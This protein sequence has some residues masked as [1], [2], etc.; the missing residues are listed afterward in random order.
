MRAVV[1][2]APL[3]QADGE[4]RPLRLVM[5]HWG[6]GEPTLGSDYYSFSPLVAYHSKAIT[7]E[8]LPYSE[9]W[10]EDWICDRFLP[11]Q[12]D[13]CISL[14]CGFGA[15]ERMLY[16]RGLFRECIAYDISPGALATARRLAEEQGLT[17]LRYEQADINHLQLPAASCDLV[18]ANGALHHITRLEHVLEQVHTAL[19]PGGI[20]VACEYVGP[21]HQNLP[22]RQRELV[23][24]VSYLLPPELRDR[25]PGSFFPPAFRHA[26]PLKLAYSSWQQFGKGRRNDAPSARPGRRGRVERGFH[27]AG[28]FVGRLCP[29]DPF[30]F[31]KLWDYDPRHFRRIDPSEC[32]RSSDVIPV[33]RNVFADVDVR[34]FHGSLLQHA[35]DGAFYRNF[36]SGNRHHWALLDQLVGIER[37]AIERGEI[38]SDNA[39][40]IAR[41]AVA[42]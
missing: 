17:G 1:E 16:A 20:L 42:P 9:S 18:W 14:C 32:V 8:R 25:Q 4:Q 37:N 26:L 12:I 31:S 28:R 7:G 24:A 5:E 11:P 34:P 35:L 6:R 39:V 22:T 2:A 41:K 38:G 21:N 19:K 30:V 3:H 10:L 36:D 29:A 27:A 23:N 13:S 40:I 15:L 33:V